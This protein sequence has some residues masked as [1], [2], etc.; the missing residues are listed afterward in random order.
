MCSCRF[1]YYQVSRQRLCVS[2]GGSPLPRCY[3]A[4]HSLS[5]VRASSASGDS[6]TS[7]ISDACFINS[8]AF[9]FTSKSKYFSPKLDKAIPYPRRS[10]ISRSMTNASTSSP[11]WL[12]NTMPIHFKI[13]RAIR[14]SKQPCRS[15][16][17]LTSLC[18]ATYRL[19]VVPIVYM[20]RSSFG[21]CIQSSSRRFPVS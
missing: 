9:S 12:P 5:F 17:S 1:S 7:N 4:P 10:P 13:L 16:L 6:I 2:Q 3:S 11:I 19:P 18:P 20:S 8:T 21:R 14:V 15:K